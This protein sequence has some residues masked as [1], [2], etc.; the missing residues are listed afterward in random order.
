MRDLDRLL[1]EE[2]E[3]SHRLSR[4]DR[5]VGCPPWTVWM[6]FAVRM[7]RR[8]VFYLILVGVLVAWWALVN[9][10]IPMVPSVLYTSV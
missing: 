9:P 4:G 2:V 7:E 3:L 6:P 5:A 8:E 10:K 1:E